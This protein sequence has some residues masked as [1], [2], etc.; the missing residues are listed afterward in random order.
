M[1]MTSGSWRCARRW[2]HSKHAAPFVTPRISCG[3]EVKTTLGHRPLPAHRRVGAPPVA[4]R[5]HARA[6][7]IHGARRRLLRRWIGA[8]VGGVARAS[9]HRRGGVRSMVMVAA[10]DDA[11]VK[12]QPVGCTCN[13]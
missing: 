11:H 7:R 10:E 8:G 9:R 12:S 4:A 5:M 6:R 13:M 3:K 1:Q 2:M